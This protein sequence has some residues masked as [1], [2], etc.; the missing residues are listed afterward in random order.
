[1]A[2]GTPTKAAA[3]FAKPPHLFQVADRAYTALMNSAHLM[4]SAGHVD[5]EDPVMLLEHHVP[6]GTVRNQSII[7][8]GESGAGKTEATKIIMKYLARI[9][10]S[11]RSKGASAP[12]MSPDG[13]MLAAL[14]DRVLSS[15][16]LLETFGNA[17]TLRNDNSSRFG[18][19]I[20][21][22]FN[23]TSGSITGASISKY[24]HQKDTRLLRKN[25]PNTR[26]NRRRHFSLFSLH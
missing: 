22:Y 1:M 20:H 24:V 23:T 7:I 18:K 10:R 14:E 9:T 19:F 17:Q 13:K 2:G 25:P 26:S 5:D 15:N 4:G 12:F 3:E 8:S 6:P 21:I 16:P 11:G